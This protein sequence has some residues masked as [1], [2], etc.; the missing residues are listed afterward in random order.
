MRSCPKFSFLII[1]FSAVFLSFMW[2]ACLFAEESV[3]QEK[4]AEPAFPYV[5]ESVGVNVNVRSGPGTNYYNC[6][7]LDRGQRV[8]VVGTRFSWSRIVPPEGCFSWISK[9]YVEVD[10]ND[11][12]SGVVT[13]DSVRVYAGSESLKPM[14]STTVQIKLNRSDKVKLLGGDSGGYYK[15][16]PPEGTYLWMS[17]E[18]LKA[19]GPVGE[20]AMVAVEPAESAEPV[21]PAVEGASQSLAETSLS[22]EAV[23]LREY[24]AIQKRAE[25]ERAKPMADQDYAEMKKALSDILSDKDA[26]KAAR[27]AEM[28]LQQIGRYELAFEI[29]K[30]VELQNKQ[31]EQIKERIVQARAKKLA[32]VKN[33]GD[34]CVIGKLAGSDVY[35]SAYRIVDDGGKTVCYALPAEGASKQDL[36]KLV[37]RKVGLVGS[38]E[39]HPE[40]SGAMVRFVKI[41]ELQ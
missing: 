39:P 5:G 33:L 26:G 24:Y 9:Q 13:G 35:V 28:A 3:E 25:T 37:G 41:V 2:S 31:L 12:A 11:V 10:A 7:K 27:Y 6:G 22:A 8:K 16:A 18:Y 19:L 38:I 23:R 40:T 30:E 32:E 15:I 1:L 17:S 4:T 20:I 21:E 36:D 29:G 14:H 34:Y